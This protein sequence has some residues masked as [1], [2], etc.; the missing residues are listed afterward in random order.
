MDYEDATTEETIQIKDFNRKI[1]VNAND[2]I[3]IDDIVEETYAI[4][5]KNLLEQI[6]KD[7][8]YEGFD[9]FKK[10]IREIISKELIE[11]ESYIEKMYL[12]IISRLIEVNPESQNINLNTLMQKL[13]IKA[14]EDLNRDALTT[15]G[16]K[17]SI[18]NESK[19]EFELIEFDTLIN[20]LKD[21]FIQNAQL[22][23][24]KESANRTFVQIDDF[25]R[26]YKSISNTYLK[27]SNIIQEFEA[28]VPL[29]TQQ[30]HDSTD[31]ELL[32]YKPSQNLLIR[33]ATIS[34]LQGIPDN[35]QFWGVNPLSDSFYSY[36]EFAT[37]TLITNI[38]GGRV[39]LKF[40]RNLKGTDL[41]LNIILHIRGTRKS[42]YIGT[43]DIVLRFSENQNK[44]QGSLLYFYS[45]YEHNVVHPLL[46]GWYKLVSAIEDGD[47]KKDI[48]ILLKL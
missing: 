18:Y 48:P 3:P 2:L 22:E 6:K 33:L 1:K 5:Y 26:I 29:I 28:N 37:K 32:A 19:K 30:L 46:Q 17:I 9:Y 7:T 38:V 14:L 36:S 10:V 47:S 35:F 15:K 43:K 8:F 31:Y 23:Q 20:D 40:P 25:E 4:T 34:Y 41:Y 42:S 44:E 12:K 11:Y 16:H 27:K 21:S 13:K 39:E 24:A 45:G